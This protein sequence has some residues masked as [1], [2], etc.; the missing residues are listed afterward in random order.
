MVPRQEH[1]S[2]KQQP[3]ACYLPKQQP[4]PQDLAAT[5]EAADPQGARH[6]SAPASPHPDRG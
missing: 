1:R 3:A 5:L 6:R 2:L 4:V